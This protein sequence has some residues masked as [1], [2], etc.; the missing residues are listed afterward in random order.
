MERETK[1]KQKKKKNKKEEKWYIFTLPSTYKFS[2]RL[3]KKKGC[4]CIINGVLFPDEW[5]AVQF[6]L[7]SYLGY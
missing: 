4:M 3:K 1:T 6:P 7:F 5:L 2:I